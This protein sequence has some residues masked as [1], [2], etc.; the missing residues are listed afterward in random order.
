MPVICDPILAW[1]GF[2]VIRSQPRATETLVS[3]VT[4]SAKTSACNITPSPNSTRTARTDFAARATVHKARGGRLFTAKCNTIP[5]L[6]SASRG[7]PS[8]SHHFLAKAQR[9]LLSRRATS[10]AMSGFAAQSNAFHTTGQS[11]VE[12]SSS[13]TLRRSQ[14]E[15]LGIAPNPDP[16]RCFTSRR[17]E[18]A[19]HQRPGI[20]RRKRGARV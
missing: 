9:K 5:S 10:P 20:H 17:W 15:E 19:R 8:V 11:P 2:G 1:S 3:R 18:C 12:T 13:R 6:Q 16:R 7:T 14:A 4:G